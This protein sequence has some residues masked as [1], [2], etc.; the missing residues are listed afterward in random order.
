MSVKQAKTATFSFDSGSCSCTM[1]NISVAG[2]QRNIDIFHIGNQ[3]KSLHIWVEA[4]E[5]TMK[6][7][8]VHR[9]T[10]VV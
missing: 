9:L 7:L 2:F 3:E 6:P 10:L 1:V 8:I 4:P 5:S